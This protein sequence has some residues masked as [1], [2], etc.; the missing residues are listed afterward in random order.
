MPQQMAAPPMMN[1]PPQMYTGYQDG[2]PPNMNMADMSQPYLGDG[3]L[4]D[5]SIEAKRRRIARVGQLATGFP[6]CCGKR[7]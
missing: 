3:G 7:R 6:A 2:L 5:D 4:M 1:P